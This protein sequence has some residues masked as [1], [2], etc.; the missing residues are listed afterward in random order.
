MEVQ[1]LIL[2]KIKQDN[3][4]TYNNAN[5]FVPY[6]TFLT[7]QNGNNPRQAENTS[8]SWSLAKG[9][10]K[11]IINMSLNLEQGV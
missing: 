8:F 2:I 6:D 1:K 7:N 9:I 11:K 10:E 5:T 4:S 3:I